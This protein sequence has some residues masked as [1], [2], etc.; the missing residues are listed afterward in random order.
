MGL[1]LSSCALAVHDLA[2]ALAFYRDV[3]DAVFERIEATGAEVMQEPIDR[4]GGTRDCAF[5]DPSGNLLRFIQS[6]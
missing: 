6:R 5:L 4:P 2:K 1:G 3:C